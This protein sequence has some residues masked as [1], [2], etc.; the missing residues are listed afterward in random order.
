M[1]ADDVEVGGEWATSIEE[2]P[3][4]EGPVRSSCEEP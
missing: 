1:A 4:S 2:K 3:Q